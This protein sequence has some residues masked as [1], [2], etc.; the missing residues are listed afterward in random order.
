MK[1][2][3]KHSQ[4]PLNFIKTAKKHTLAQSKSKKNMFANIRISIPYTKH[5]ENPIAMLKSTKN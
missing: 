3:T 4:K 5:I 2:M 1:K